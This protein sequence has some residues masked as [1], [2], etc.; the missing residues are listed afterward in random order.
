M[1]F[2]AYEKFLEE[3]FWYN[4]P[5][6]YFFSKNSGIEIV[7][8]VKRQIFTISSEWHLR[9][10]QETSKNR[11]FIKLLLQLGDMFWKLTFTNK[12]TINININFHLPIIF[13]TYVIIF[14][15]NINYYLFYSPNFSM[16][17]SL[18]QTHER[19]Q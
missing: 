2:S 15:V 6:L 8:L 4:R 7:Y 13:L 19:T 3:N 12:R 17:L 9:G 18:K 16:P 10:W 11:E 1:I 14:H 5:E